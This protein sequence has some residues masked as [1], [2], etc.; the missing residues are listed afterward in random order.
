M[1]TK[2][3]CAFLLMIAICT[4]ASA[5]SRTVSTVSIG[6]ALGLNQVITD[7]TSSVIANT[8]LSDPYGVPVSG[9][10]PN[11]SATYKLPAYT[12]YRVEFII[13][14]VGNLI[15]WMR[16]GDNSRFDIPEV[17][18]L[19]DGKTVNFVPDHGQYV[20]TIILDG[21]YKPNVTDL[22]VQIKVVGGDKRTTLGFFTLWHSAN[23]DK[24][25]T[26]LPFVIAPL[27]GECTPEDIFGWQN[28]KE[29]G[30]AAIRLFSRHADLK[31]VA[32]P[33]TQKN[34][35]TTI[36][37]LVGDVDDDPITVTPSD[38]LP[39]YEGMVKIQVHA[40][41]PMAIKVVALKGKHFISPKGEKLSELHLQLK[42]NDKPLI[43]NQSMP[44]AIYVGK[45]KVFS[46]GE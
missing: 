25:A 2:V 39:G 46:Q 15:N 4:G 22:I 43:F 44:L 41:K 14:G 28:D 3:I 17:V 24:S 5:D 8:R 34:M 7:P 26:A 18:G 6:G 33:V 27:D 36:N 16:K 35:E 13:S 12:G 38:S 29:S 32:V 10:M 1:F 19:F 31:T 23:S 11:G 37:G 30:T 40:N 45:T 20:G 9:A 42:P 21:T